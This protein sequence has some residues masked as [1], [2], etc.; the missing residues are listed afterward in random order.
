MSALTVHYRVD[1]TAQQSVPVQLGVQVQAKRDCA[2]GS[3]ASQLYIM[4]SLGDVATVTAAIV[5]WLA[6]D[7]AIITTAHANQVANQAIQTAFQAALGSSLTFDV[8]LP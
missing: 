8:T 7:L 1:Y 3:S 6:A 2:L 4:N 5:A